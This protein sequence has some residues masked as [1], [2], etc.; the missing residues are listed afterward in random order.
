MDNHYKFTTTAAYYDIENSC[1]DLIT[2]TQTGLPAGD[3]IKATESGQRYGYGSC[4]FTIDTS[5]NTAWKVLYGESPTA[6]VF[7]DGTGSYVLAN[8]DNDGTG[9]AQIDTT[10]STSEEE[11]GFNIS[12][13]TNLTTSNVETDPTISQKYD[14]WTTGVSGQYVFDIEDNG[15]EDKILEDN[16][17]GAETAGEFDLNVYLN[18]ADS[19]VAADYGL[20]TWMI[21]TDGP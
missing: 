9:D 14:D 11:Y 10:G 6:T 18:A 20:E 7:N 3:P 1:S 5:T 17:N 2:I 4:T 16:G 19:T 13:G 12:P 15:S 21:L 8:I